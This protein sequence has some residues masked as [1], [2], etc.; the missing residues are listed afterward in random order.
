M[1]MSENIEGIKNTTPWRWLD[2]GSRWLLAVVFL[3]AGVPKIADP[4]AFAVIIGAYGLLPEILLLPMAIVLPLAEIGIAVALIYSRQE[5]LWGAGI[6]LLVFIA[7][8]GYG[9]Q[10]GLDID[11]GCFGPEDPEHKAFSGLRT[12][13]VRD[14]LLLIP[15]LYGSWYKYKFSNELCGEKQ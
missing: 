8:L 5:G 14:L 13:L 15:M 3:F 2:R 11:C 1:K 9:V 6:M 7:V 10:M 12:A 4:E